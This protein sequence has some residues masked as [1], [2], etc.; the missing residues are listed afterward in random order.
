MFN[1]LLKGGQVITCKAMQQLSGCQR[2]AHFLQQVALTACDLQPGCAECCCCTC[3]LVT[4]KC[5][6]F[7]FV[8]LPAITVHVSEKKLMKNMNHVSMCAAS[9]VPAAVMKNA[10]VQLA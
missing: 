7:F 9:A 1:N 5:M 4:V 8:K 3:T 2:H 10:L 6:Y